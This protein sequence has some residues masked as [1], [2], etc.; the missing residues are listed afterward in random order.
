MLKVVFFGS[1]DFVEPIIEILKKNFELVQVVT[2]QAE[3]SEKADLGIIASYGRIVPKAVIESFPYGILNIHPSL[4]PK[5]R[6]PAP[7]QTAI[8]NGDKKTGVTI[9]KL[10]EEVDHGPILEQ[11]EVE[12][13]K[14]E[15]SKSLLEK[16]FLAGAEMLTN[17]ISKYIKGEIKISPQYHS[18][19]TFT[20]ILTKKDGL[21]NV[22]NPPNYESLEKMIRAF[23]PW[24]SLWFTAKL[25]EE[26]RTIKLL[27]EKKIQVEG[28]KPMSYKDFA[29]GYAQGWDI[30]AKLDLF[31]LLD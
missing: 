7:V 11:K 23:Y 31:D 4:L 5:Y 26:K 3:L 10:D 18:E 6:G 1:G 19:A 21:I 29:N 25:G 9:I 28:K 22:N 27:P 20:K 24:P 14:D 13:S 30:L 17:V 15:T 8:L 12:I 16:T 2:T